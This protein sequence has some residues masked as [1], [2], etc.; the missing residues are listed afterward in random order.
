MSE[1]LEKKL[2][3]T[4]HFS[5]LIQFAIAMG[6]QIAFD[7]EH[8]EHMPA[9]L[10]YLGLAK[11]INLYKN[12]VYLTKTEDYKPLGKFWKSLDNQCCWGGDFLDGCH[13]SIRYQGKS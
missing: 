1:L 13:F 4:N 2:K 6:Y 10:H 9:S 11:D 12:G 8:C 3:F 7:K 5:V